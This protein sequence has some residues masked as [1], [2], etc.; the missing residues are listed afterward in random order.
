MTLTIDFSN[1]A[2]AFVACVVLLVIFILAIA[3]EGFV[4]FLVIVTAFLALLSAVWM[5]IR[6]INGAP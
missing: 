4:G 5:A 6:L 2:H 3:D 1:P